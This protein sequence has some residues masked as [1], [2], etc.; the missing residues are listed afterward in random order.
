MTLDN[1]IDPTT[2]TDAQIRQAIIHHCIKM[3]SFGYYIEDEIKWWQRVPEG[4]RVWR[5]VDGKLRAYHVRDR[6]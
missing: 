4:L 2:L 5:D 6:K 1:T 3:G